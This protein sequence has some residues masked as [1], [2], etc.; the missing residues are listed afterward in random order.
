MAD[1]KFIDD[2]IECHDIFSE[3]VI[4]DYVIVG[5]KQES[6]KYIKKFPDRVKIVSSSSF[7]LIGTVIRPG[8]EAPVFEFGIVR[9]NE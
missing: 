4:H 9:D 3:K 1:E 7:L 5:E 2:V 6:Y 8:L